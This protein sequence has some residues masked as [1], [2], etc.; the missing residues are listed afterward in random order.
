MEGFAGPELSLLIL[1]AALGFL[2]DC[3]KLLAL[4]SVSLGKKR[5]RWRI[6]TVLIIL[7]EL[8]TTVIVCS[9]G[10]M[11]SRVLIDV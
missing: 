7:P 6:R 8:L 11:G 1:V 3:E 10:M 4:G 9:S 5:R 2:E